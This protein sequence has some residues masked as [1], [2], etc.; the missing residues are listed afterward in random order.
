MSKD[1][2]TLILL[3]SAP[4]AFSFAGN[5]QELSAAAGGKLRFFILAKTGKMCIIIH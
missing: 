5:I 4:E 3:P 1:G 2:A